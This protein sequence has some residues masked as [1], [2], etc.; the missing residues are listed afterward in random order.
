[1]TKKNIKVLGIDT[2]TRMGS[3]AL[4]EED[5][6]LGEYI[7]FTKKGHS[8]KLLAL[9]HQL[10][11][12]SQQNLDDIDL[13]GVSAGPGSF[14]G[15]RVG[16]STA[17]GLAFSLGKHL[18]GVPTLEVM[19]F[20]ATWYKGNIC[21]MIDSRKQQVYTCLFKSSGNGPPKRMTQ[22]TV[23]EPEKWLSTI[24]EPTVFL[25][26]GVQLYQEIIKEMMPPGSLIL[27]PAMG[28]S[29]A[30]T[31][32][33]LALQYQLCNK[34][35]DLESISPLYV[36]PPDAELSAQDRKGSFQPFPRQ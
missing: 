12:E 29:R 5:T 35:S 3:V 2:T 9:I 36:R 18:I 13:V 16:I 25:G 8:I 6:I 11:T 4:L 27:P 31:V 28:I 34:C 1:L 23:I 30:S 24:K 19:A 10:L 22:E 32:A 20:Q 17:Q 26:D 21:P 7:L 15:L 14:T 33:Q